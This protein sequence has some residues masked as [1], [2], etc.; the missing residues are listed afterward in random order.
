LSDRWQRRW[1]CEEG[2]TLVELLVV[3]LI[4]GI[5]AAIA[6]PSFLSQEDKANDGRAKAQVRTAETAAESYSTDHGGG[7]KELSVEALKTIEPSLKDEVTAKLLK[8]EEGKEGGY[9]VESESPKTKDTFTIER[10]KEGG[11]NRTCTKDGT[12]SCPSSGLW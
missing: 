8:A 6:L 4:I 7:Y 9:I 5:L 1:E 12:G 10:T 3:I 2:F 11:I